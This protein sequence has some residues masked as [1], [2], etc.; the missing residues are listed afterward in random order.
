MR[1]IRSSLA[2]ADIVEPECPGVLADA[3]IKTHMADIVFTCLEPVNKFL[4]CRRYL[5]PG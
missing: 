5:V 4:P 1:T 3:D 2:K